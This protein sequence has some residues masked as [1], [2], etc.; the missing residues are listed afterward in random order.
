MHRL[1]VEVTHRIMISFFYVPGVFATVAL[2]PLYRL[3]FDQSLDFQSL[4]EQLSDVFVYQYG[5]V[6]TKT[7]Y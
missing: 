6:G 3:Y 2:E 4:Y 5:V 7:C 1:F